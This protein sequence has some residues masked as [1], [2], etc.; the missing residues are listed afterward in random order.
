M[1][2][3]HVRGIAAT[4]F[5]AL[6]W[7]A[8]PVVAQ[9]ADDPPS[10]VGAKVSAGAKSVAEAVKR[11]AK[12]VAQKAKEGAK[13]VAASSKEIA[14]HVAASS[15]QGAHEVAAAAKKGAEKTR[16]AFKSDGAG[17]E[18]KQEKPENSPD[19]KPQR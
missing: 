17:K 14:H 19:H 11:D 16:A 1:L 12:V 8:C 15:K 18:D 9:A 6:C 13:Q 4:L 2:I 5:V 10:D 7:A 3:P